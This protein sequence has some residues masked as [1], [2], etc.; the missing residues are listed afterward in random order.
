MS[1][2]I[3]WNHWN[4]PLHIQWKLFRH[5][6]IQCSIAENFKANGTKDFCYKL[7]TKQISKLYKHKKLKHSLKSR[8]SSGNKAEK[9][10]LEAK[11]IVKIKL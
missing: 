5:V 8:S 9:Q 6:T 4:V 3:N 7:K 11:T 1:L 2:D 10:M